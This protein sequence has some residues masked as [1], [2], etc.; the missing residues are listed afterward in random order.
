MNQQ[1]PD[2]ARLVPERPPT[3]DWNAP[4][5]VPTRDFLG[6]FNLDW[7]WD[8]EE[9]VTKFIAAV[10]QGGFLAWEAAV[11]SEQGLPV[12]AAQQAGIQRLQNLV[13]DDAADDAPHLRDLPRPH[14]PWYAI[15][16][17]IVPQLLVEPFRTAEVYE[18]VQYDG[19]FNI[20]R[21]LEEH[22]SGLS[23]PAGVNSIL[24]VVPAEL[25]HKLWVQSCCVEL[26][27]LG[28]ADDMTLANEEEQFRVH[29]FLQRLP[30]CKESVEFLDLTL[31]SLL[32]RL[33]LPDR[34]G[35]IFMHMMQ[36]K[37]GLRSAAERLAEY[38]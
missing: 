23:L 6:G 2:D 26:A 15:L 14:E 22:G 27:G 1:Q 38:L 7:P 20:A 17:K 37:L 19:W 13:E 4:P 21:C 3:L 30:R 28:Q 35:P 5:G 18:D 10:E 8:L 12:T 29:R 32:G 34:D 11:C 9:A 33:I 31:D 24:E 36:E 25:R 16:N